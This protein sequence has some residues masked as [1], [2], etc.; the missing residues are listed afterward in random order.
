MG[1][2]HTRRVMAEV[3]QM[4]SWRNLAYEQPVGEARSVFQTFAVPEGPVVKGSCARPQPA[5]VRS[6]AVNISPEPI[7]RCGE[8]GCPESPVAVVMDGA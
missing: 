7:F 5:V 6:L 3:M 4:A 8:F 1:G 2:V